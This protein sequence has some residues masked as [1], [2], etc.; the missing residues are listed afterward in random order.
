[1][2]IKKMYEVNDWF[3]ESKGLIPE[4]SLYS[5]DYIEERFVIV[6]DEQKDEKVI[7]L[8]DVI[9]IADTLKEAEAELKE[10]LR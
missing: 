3:Y 7:D 4:H 8:Y 2:I 1:M 5:N 9:F 6:E 10:R